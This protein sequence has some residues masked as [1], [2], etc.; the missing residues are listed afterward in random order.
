MQCCMRC[1]IPH[2]LRFLVALTTTHISPANHPGGG[3]RRFQSIPRFF[4]GKKTSDLTPAQRKL[5]EL[6]RES[7]LARKTAEAVDNSELERLWSGLI[8]DEEHADENGSV[9]L[10]FEQYASFMQREEISP[11]FKPFFT[12]NVF[13]SLRR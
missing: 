1:C 5:R 12:P 3:C 2:P 7:H 11:K 6:A 9:M 10:S 13:L 8:G 4:F